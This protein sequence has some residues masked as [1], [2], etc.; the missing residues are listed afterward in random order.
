VITYED[1][2][3][4]DIRVGRILKVED[5]PQARKP[6]YIL[7]IDFGPEIGVKKSSAQLTTN[8]TKEELIGK[9]VIAV[10]NF[11]VKRIGPFLSEVLT[12]GLPDG[13]GGVVLLCPTQEVPLGGKMF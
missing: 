5:F 7:E 11:P 13:N 4:V 1:F 6:A 10:V 8:Y 3:K 9:L 2:E 12:L